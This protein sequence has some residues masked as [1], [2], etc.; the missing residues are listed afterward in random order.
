MVIVHSN[1]MWLTDRVFSQMHVT[2]CQYLVCVLVC[3]G[4]WAGGG[5]A[6]ADFKHFKIAN[7]S[8]KTLQG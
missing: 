6:L 7:I 4:G 1:S 5:Y 8:G 2:F 3:G